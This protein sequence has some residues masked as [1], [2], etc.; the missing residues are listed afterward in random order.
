MDAIYSVDYTI[1]SVPTSVS[2]ECPHCNEEVELPF[3][4]RFWEGYEE[5]KCPEC[6]NKVRLCEWDY[7]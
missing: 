3:E 1:T 5:V 4:T 7:D 2:F 6:N